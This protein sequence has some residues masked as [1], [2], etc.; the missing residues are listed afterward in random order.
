MT[1]KTVKNLFNYYA[2][3]WILKL[4][5]DKKYKFI[6]K[7][8]NRINAYADVDSL[9]NYTYKIRFNT[10]KYKHKWQIIHVVLH[11]L[12][13]ILYDFRSGNDGEHEYVAELFALNMARENYP[14]FYQKM[15]NWTKKA[16]I[17]KTGD[18]IGKE[19]E[20]GYTKALQ[21]LGELI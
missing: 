9:G 5:L 4:G 6:I 11:E 19:H 2:G 7:K 18:E 3:H 10:K 12:G 13:H 20:Y 14:E 8:D 16:L 15:I 21:E 1:D 17:K